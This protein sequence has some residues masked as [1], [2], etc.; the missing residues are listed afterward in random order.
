MNHDINNDS[1]MDSM[2]LHGGAAGTG[3]VSSKDKILEAGAAATQVKHTIFH[4]PAQRTS[5][6]VSAYTIC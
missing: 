3:P 5:T 4:Y 6:S 1:T 2:P